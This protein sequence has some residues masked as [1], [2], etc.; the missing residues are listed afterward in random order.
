M[1]IE[2][3]YCNDSVSSYRIGHVRL[4]VPVRRNG[5]F[6]HVTKLRIV[7]IPVCSQHYES[8]PSHL[9]KGWFS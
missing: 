9:A 5:L 7:P 2:C 1:S 8:P 4:D 3:R 6:Y